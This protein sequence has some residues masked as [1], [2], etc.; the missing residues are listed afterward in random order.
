MKQDHPSV[1]IVLSSVVHRQDDSALNVK[2]DKVNS[3]L[4]KFCQQ[5]SIEFIN[6]N[7]I[8]AKQYLNRSSINLN[9]KGSSVL[10]AN[11]RF[12]VQGSLFP[13]YIYKLQCD[14]Q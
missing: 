5:S 12:K 7:N 1:E 9:G 4:E 2:I 14:V 6:N 10:A 11:S 13:I 3:D 8:K